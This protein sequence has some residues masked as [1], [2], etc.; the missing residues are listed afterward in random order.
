MRIIEVAKGG[1]TRLLPTKGMQ[2]LAPGRGVDG[3]HCAGQI[4]LQMH[5]L[6]ILVLACTVLFSSLFSSTAPGAAELDGDPFF[7]R[8]AGKW[9]G[10]GE[11]FFP[12]V[13]K[14]IALSSRLSAEFHEDGRL[15]IREHRKEKPSSPI[16]DPTEPRESLRVLWV[17]AKERGLYE[18]GSGSGEAGMPSSTEASFDGQI[19]RVEDRKAGT[20]SH[21]KEWA[22]E[23]RSDD[24]VLFWERVMT[25]SE[26]KME[27]RIGFHRWAG[28]PQGLR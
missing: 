25:G 26:V 20:P 2:N 13:G 17:R 1:E 23:F 18:L 7:S 5:N 10:D 9:V 22:L 12:W 27:T 19:F 6:R 16:A 3:L 8:M 24:E 15:V 11:R 14:R 28:I 21:L 4:F